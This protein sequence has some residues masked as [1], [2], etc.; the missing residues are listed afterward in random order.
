MNCSDVVLAFCAICFTFTLL[1]A[2]KCYYPMCME[3]PL[4]V[5][6]GYRIFVLICASV[7]Q[8]EM[9]VLCFECTNYV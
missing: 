1:P 6:A 5:M 9:N 8:E 2:L 7:L 4:S 3:I